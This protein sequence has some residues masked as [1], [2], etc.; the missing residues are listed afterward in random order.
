M[1]GDFVQA[2]Y[3]R[4]GEDTL[5]GLDT[6]VDGGFAMGQN[7]PLFAEGELGGD[8]GGTAVTTSDGEQKVIPKKADFGTVSSGGLY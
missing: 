7:L 1:S 8:E 3:F 6:L 4:D 5:F 2:E